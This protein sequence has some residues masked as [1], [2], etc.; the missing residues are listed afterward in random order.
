MYKFNHSPDQNLKY[1]PFT[2]LMLF[3]LVVFIGI[4]AGSLLCFLLIA[5]PQTGFDTAA[6]QHFMSS[7][8][9]NCQNVLICHALQGVALFVPFVMFPILYFQ[10]T[11]NKSITHLFHPDVSFQK[12]A[13]LFALGILFILSVYPLG[14]A[15]RELTVDLVNEGLFG[16]A[17]KSILLHEESQSELIEAMLNVHTPLEYLSLF[18]IIAVLPGF[19]EELVFRG[20]IQNIFLKLQLNHHL[21]IILTAILFSGLH[22]NLTEFLPRVL[23]GAVLGYTYYYSKNF[24]IPVF[25]HFANNALSIVYYV[26]LKSGDIEFD[27]EASGQIDALDISVGIIITISSWYFFKRIADKSFERKNDL[28]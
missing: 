17:G 11:E 14:L 1:P 18:L 19:G 24:W 7:T 16:E 25:L 2:S 13:S 10:F 5:L 9:A 4:I 21:A 27:M 23:L 6:A 20:V 22:F 8:I 28:V 12:Q 15:L 3:I 26:Y